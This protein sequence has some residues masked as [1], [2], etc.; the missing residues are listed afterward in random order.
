MA[1]G[2]HR[3]QRLADLREREGLVDRQGK[4]AGLDRR[5]QVG[6][7]PRVD[8]ANLLGRPA[9]EGDADIVDAFGRV[10]VEVEFAGHAA[11]PADIDDAA[12]DRRRRE[13]LVRDPA[14][15]EVDD[16][17]DALA[18]GGLLDLVRPAGRAG[19]VELPI[20]GDAP[21]SLAICIP[22]RPT[23]ELAPWTSSVSPRLRR[24]AVTMALCMVASATGTQAGCSY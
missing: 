19:L 8:V 3:R 20:T 6:V 22:I 13:I 11:Q 5:P 15:Y 14:R 12:E 4:R 7:H 21:I 23:P 18:A 17:V 16:H 10:Q 9:T 1:V 24:P 2:P